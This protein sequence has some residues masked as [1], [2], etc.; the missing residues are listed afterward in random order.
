MATASIHTTAQLSTAISELGLESHVLE[1][2]L[3]GLTVVPP[4]VHGFGIDRCDQAVDLILQRAEELTASSFSLEQGPSKRLLFPPRANVLAGPDADKGEPTQFML[5]QL[6][7]YH[8][9]F[10]DLAINP[11]SVALVRH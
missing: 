6:M 2:E 1:L 8:R 9:V 7:S 11:V 10:R 4:E 5:H 3:N